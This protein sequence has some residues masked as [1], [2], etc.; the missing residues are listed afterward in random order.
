[1]QGHHLQGHCEGCEEYRA[2][3]DGLSGACAA[4][5][6]SAGRLE[7][8]VE[9]LTVVCAQASGLALSAGCSRC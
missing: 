9:G 7:R 5:G 3:E 1:M 8:A 6:W 2:T 4:Q